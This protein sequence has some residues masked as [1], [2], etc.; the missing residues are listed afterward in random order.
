MMPA[1]LSRSVLSH[2][3][4]LAVLPVAASGWSDW[5]SPQRVLASLAGTDGHRRLL[6]RWIPT[7]RS[8]PRRRWP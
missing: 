5:G 2:A 3:G 4:R 7:T 8:L 6:A 1:N